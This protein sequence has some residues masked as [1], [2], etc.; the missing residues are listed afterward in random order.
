MIRP[1]SGD[2]LSNYQIVWVAREFPD[3]DRP[4]KNWTERPEYRR[5][6]ARTSTLYDYCSANL[7]LNPI[8]PAANPWC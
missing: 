6:S 1:H 3:P 4:R 7:S 8:S 2:Q 5:T